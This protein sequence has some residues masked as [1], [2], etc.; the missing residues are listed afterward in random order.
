M[1]MTATVLLVIAGAYVALVALMCLFQRSLLYLPWGVAPS[2]AAAGVPEM[3]EVTLETADGLSLIAWYRPARSQRPT[4][5]YFHGNGGHIGYRAG[6]VRPYL[7]AGFGVLLVEYRGYGGNPGRPTEQGLYADGRAAL[8]HLAADAVPPQRV[9]VYGESLGSGVAVH[10][11][12]EQAVS[13]APVAAVVLEAPLTSVADV[14]AHHYP[15]L[16]VRWLAKDR[17]ETRSKIADIGAPLLVVHGERDSIVPVRFGRAVFEAAQEPKE[18]V[19]VARA[20]HEDL[21]LY[22]LQREVIG[23]LQRRLRL[24]ED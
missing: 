14:G 8:R 19:W 21:D 7:D 4:I 5:L 22:G 10:L 9:V 6:R 24:G 11:A 13:A 18:S 15:F 17:F 3:A 2:P 16:P 20:G 1:R 12:R 23:F